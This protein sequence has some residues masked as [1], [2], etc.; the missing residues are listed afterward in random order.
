MI[1]R[2]QADR[3]ADRQ[4]AVQAAR[5]TARRAWNIGDIGDIG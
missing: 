1:A 5:Q 2:P 3:Q 4:T